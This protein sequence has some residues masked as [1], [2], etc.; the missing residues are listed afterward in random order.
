MHEARKDRKI[1]FLRLDKLIIRDR[2]LLGVQAKALQV[3]LPVTAGY[4]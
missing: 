4:E 2:P 1:A 3:Q